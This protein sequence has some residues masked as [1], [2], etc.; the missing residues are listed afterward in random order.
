[1]RG[2]LCCIDASRSHTLIIPLL[3]FNRLCIV[4]W[5][6]D[7][8]LFHCLHMVGSREER[9]G[10]TPH[11]GHVGLPVLLL[12]LAAFLSATT[13]HDPSCRSRRRDALVGCFSSST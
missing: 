13:G 7:M 11:A 6:S 5:H 3:I 9:P 1:M 2:G 10:M 4:L 12:V 8:F